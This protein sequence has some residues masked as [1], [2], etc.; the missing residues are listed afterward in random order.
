MIGVVYKLL[1]KHWPTCVCPLQLL[2]NN[3]SFSTYFQI[4]LILLMLTLAIDTVAMTLLPTYTELAKQK[5]NY[6]KAM[7]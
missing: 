2:M 4:C 5:V 7:L 3:D 6:I 1:N